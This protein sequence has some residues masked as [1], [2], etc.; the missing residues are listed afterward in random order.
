V[1]KLDWNALRWKI[2]GFHKALKSGCLAENSQLRTSDRVVKL[3]AMYCIV[4]WRIFWMALANQRDT[5][6]RVE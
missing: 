4:S 1:V 6:K 2:E 5:H 3:L